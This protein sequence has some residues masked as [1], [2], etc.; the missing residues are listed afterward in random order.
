MIYNFDEPINRRGTY[1]VKWDG[2]DLIKEMGLT[3]RYDED[4]IPLFTA[5]MDLPAPQP[6]VDALYATVDHRIFG[7]SIFPEEYYSAIQNWFARKHDWTIQKEEIVYCPGTVLA[8]N[9]VVTAF[10]DAGD[11]II[12]QRPS[13]P[14]FASAVEGNE[15][16]LLNNH[17]KQDEAGKYQIDFEDFEENAKLG[18]TKMFILCNLHNPTG[19]IFSD[20]YLIRLSDICRENN[21]LLVADE[22]HGDIVRKDSQFTPVAALVQD[23]AH[24]ITLTAIN[25]TFNVAGLHCSNIIIT[26][27][28]RRAQ[29]K[30]E[31]GMQMPSPFTIAALIAAYNEGDEW[32]EQLNG[33]LDDTVDFTASF[34]K[35]NM[36]KVQFQIPE[37]TYVMWLDFSGYGLSPEAVHDRIYNKANVLLEDGDMFG[38]DNRGFQR[39]CLPSPRPLIKE[40]L[41]RISAQFEDLK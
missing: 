4:T 40:V 24:I 21:V 13:Y 10:T 17:L 28:D 14:P 33:Y 29:F 30:N 36:P 15:R 20:E 26:N 2:G 38:E 7:Y 22:I 34:L 18:S 39:I 41:E 5:D 11:G 19:R 37:G 12:I 23:T 9:K 32:L 1:S 27:P 6:V 25:K 31:L 8:V 35:E 3:E 16:V